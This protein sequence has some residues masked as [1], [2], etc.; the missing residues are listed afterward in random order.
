MEEMGIEPV[1]SERA[2]QEEMGVEVVVNSLA[3]RE[4]MGV[5]VVVNSLAWRQA[6]QVGVRVLLVWETYLF[7]EERWTVKIL[8]LEGGRSG[9]GL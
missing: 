2:W 7:W 1:V 3:W 8:A 9:P 5:E 6:R 4:E